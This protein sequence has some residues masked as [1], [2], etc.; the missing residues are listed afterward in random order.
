MLMRMLLMCSFTACMAAQ[1][2]FS[3]PQPRYSVRE[4]A[5]RTGTSIR[6]TLAGPVVIP[7]NL[8]YE[9]LATADRLKFH[10]NYESIPD[11][12]E[13]PFPR[14]GLRTLL[15][16]ITKAQQKLL[17]R[18]DLFLVAAVSAEGVVQQVTAYG[19]PSETMKDFAVQI[20][21]A[22][23]FKPARC[24]GAPCAME[25]PLRMQFAVR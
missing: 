19:A 8:D 1:P 3:Q 17:V 21:F 12:D 6:R 14:G 22:T 25:F 4:D 24:A 10:E 16:P 11:G 9:Q 18:G 2:V 15:D 20:L 13:P 7:V 5:P 23:A